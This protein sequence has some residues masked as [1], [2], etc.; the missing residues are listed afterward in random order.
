[1]FHSNLQ[2]FG[3]GKLA[4]RKPILRQKKVETCPKREAAGIY[5]IKI[6]SVYQG[7]MISQKVRE[8][9]KILTQLK[10][11][12]ICVGM[13]FYILTNL[14]SVYSGCLF[15]ETFGVS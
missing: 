1:M 10:Y 3:V 5:V 9:V 4:A 13:L 11:F 14:T 12:L 2:P 15:G 6:A 7:I 8:F